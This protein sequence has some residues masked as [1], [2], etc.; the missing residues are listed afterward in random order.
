MDYHRIVI[1]G[2]NP[3]E[4]AK[5]YR[6]KRLVLIYP[7]GKNPKSDV[8]L[9]KNIMVLHSE[10]SDFPD[11]ES[12]KIIR[13][14]IFY[15]LN[16]SIIGQDER[17]L[18][19]FSKKGER[20]EI[21]MD[22]RELMY[23]SILEMLND[24]LPGELVEKLLRLA[25]SIVLKGREGYPMGALLVVGDVHNVERY[26]IQKIGNP[27]KSLSPHLRNVLNEENFETLREFAMMDGAMIIDSRGYAITCG[28]YIKS[29][30]VDEWSSENLGGRH[31][32]GQSITKLT[33][34]VSFVVSSEGE[35]R[36]YKDGRKIY[37]L[38]GF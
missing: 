13:D 32:A 24:R 17:I 7:R 14:W 27:L 16:A 29:L 6:G 19:V 37:E 20:Y 4:L 35:I 26:I 22:M 11:I 10:Y 18:F 25:M 12:L 1:M 30:F 15:L 2:D 36:I 5:E 9:N 28:A 21:S 34:A 8:L 38:E 33:R 31:L 3:G 23:P